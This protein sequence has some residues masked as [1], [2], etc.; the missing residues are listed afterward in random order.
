MSTNSYERTKDLSPA[1]F[2]SE[3]GVLKEANW[4]ENNP[5]VGHRPLYWKKEPL[6]EERIKELFEESGKSPKVFA[7]L[8]EQEHGIR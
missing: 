7:R 1:Y 4:D 5:P 2:I 3:F 6:S 8:I